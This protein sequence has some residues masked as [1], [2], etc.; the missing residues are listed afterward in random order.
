MKVK[1]VKQ[2]V[3][4]DKN[5]KTQRKKINWKKVVS[6]NPRILAILYII[7]ITIF[8]FDESVISLPFIVHLFPT[9]ILLLILI[10]TWKK[11]LGA[12]IIFLIAF[13]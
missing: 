6:W 1:R 11:P 2:K 9:I 12:G 4:P 10:F 13:T 5:K 3:K 7:F 8:A